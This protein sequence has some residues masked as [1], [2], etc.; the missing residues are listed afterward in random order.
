MNTEEC[1]T[2]VGPMIK[3]ITILCDFCIEF[4]KLIVRLPEDLGTAGD[5]PN[6]IDELVPG[7]GL[8]SCQLCEVISSI[9]PTTPADLRTSLIRSGFESRHRSFELRPRVCGTEIRGMRFRIW[10]DIGQKLRSCYI[11]LH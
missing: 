8:E 9:E 2:T 3:D 11:W 4:T 10:A 1:C 5:Q 7:R 6:R